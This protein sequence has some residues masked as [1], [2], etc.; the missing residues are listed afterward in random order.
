MLW[1]RTAMIRRRLDGSR[2]PAAVLWTTGL[3]SGCDEADMLPRYQ[4]VSVVVAPWI[5][6]T[7]STDRSRLRN[8]SGCLQSDVVGA[9]ADLIQ[10]MA[11]LGSLELQ[12]R[13]V[14]AF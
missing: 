10:E 6:G 14:R 4:G 2:P 5:N 13:A 7:R 12:D 3:Q 9:A 11:P 8:R 1:L